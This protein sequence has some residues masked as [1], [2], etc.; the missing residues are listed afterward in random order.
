MTEG[1]ARL[2]EQLR[3]RVKALEDQNK[4]LIGLLADENNAKKFQEQFEQARADAMENV[5]A[6]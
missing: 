1:E 4:W 5:D 2:V 6:A 3:R